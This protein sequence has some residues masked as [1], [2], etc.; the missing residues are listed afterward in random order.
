MSIPDALF[1]FNRDMVLP[2]HLL[3]FIYNQDIAYHYL[4]EC[5]LFSLTPE[6][7]PSMQAAFGVTREHNNTPRVNACD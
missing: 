6:P 1:S 5:I 4:V 2:W 3:N 7:T